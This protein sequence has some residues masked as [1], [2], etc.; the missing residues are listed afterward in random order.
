MVVLP[1]RRIVRDDHDRS[2]VG[3]RSGAV[4]KDDVAQAQPKRAV[5]QERKRRGHGLEA[6][7]PAFRSHC[8]GQDAG[9]PARI[10]AD[11]EDVVTLVHE[12]NHDV[13]FR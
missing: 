2:A 9:V 1:S 13:R 11:V 4:V 3:A 8:L 12:G 7:H 6:V 10:G 5:A